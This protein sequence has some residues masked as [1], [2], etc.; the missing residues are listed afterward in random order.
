MLIPTN[1]DK[2]EIIL[3]VIAGPKVLVLGESDNIETGNTKTVGNDEVKIFPSRE[4]VS[5]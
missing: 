4:L 5:S 1:F 2:L 3:S